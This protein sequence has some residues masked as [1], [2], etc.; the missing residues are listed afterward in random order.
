MEH[1]LQSPNFQWRLFH[2][3]DALW[4]EC[5]SRQT[6]EKFGP[7][8]LLALEV[9]LAFLRR[10]QRYESYEVAQWQPNENGIR[11]MVRLGEWGISAALWFELEGDELR[12]QFFPHEMWEEKA[13]A[14]RLFALDVLPDFASTS[15]SG[16]LLLPLHHGSLCRVAGKPKISDRFL[17]YLEQPRWELSPTFPVVAAHDERGGW[18]LLATHGAGDI[19]CRVAT[20]G[21]GGGHVG[22]GFSLRRLWIDP[23]DPDTREFRLIP[24]SP[25]DDMAHAVAKRLR[26]HVVELGKPTLSERAQESPEVAYLMRSCVLKLFHG[27]C[28]QGGCFDSYPPNDLP[29]QHFFNQMTFAEAGEV[30]QELKAAGVE[31]L[32][33]QS[34]GWNAGGHDG[35]YPSRFPIEPRLGGESGFRAMVQNGNALGYAMSVHDNFQMNVPHSPDWDADCLIQD[36]FGQ[37][38]LRGWWAGGPEYATWYQALPPARIE[39]HLERVKALGVRGLYYCD[40]Q[41]APLEV[42]Y[43]PRHRGGRLAHSAGQV[44]LLE[45]VKK[46]CGAV[47]TEF[48]A[49][50]AL[51]TCD[52]VTGGALPDLRGAARE[53]GE[54]LAQ[55]ADELVPLR[56]LVFS[57]LTLIQSDEAPSMRDALDAVAFGLVPRAECTLRPGPIGRR[58]DANFI[59]QMAATY[60]FAAEFGHLRALEITRCQSSENGSHIVTDYADGTHVEADYNAARLWVNQREIKLH[61][62]F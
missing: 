59:A 1:I 47:G 48:G 52:V 3:D 8:R 35:L 23:I 4:L 54:A 58:A 41:F 15:G 5:T 45:R 39:G 42:N 40:Y 10:T 14:Y 28:N 36:A 9:H 22:F 2:Q 33:V 7:S 20:D 29:P 49:F 19:E 17:L 21:E 6:G 62:L 46:F 53:S 60:Q 30:L 55:L 38:L 43:H 44:E 37:P 50:P 13:V 34:V 26:R 32:L 31:Q 11:V 56:S 16:Q 18:M 57:G 61:E 25:D 51:V 12:V 24:L 27:I